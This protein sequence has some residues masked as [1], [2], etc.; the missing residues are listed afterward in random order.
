MQSVTKEMTVW[1]VFLGG[2]S[3]L[4]PRV[5][6]VLL[7]PALSNQM[8]RSATVILDKYLPQKILLVLTYPSKILFVTY[9]VA[10]TA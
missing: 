1:I 7:Y 6:T 9:Q 3:R 4:R 8:L 2:D 10:T 5:F